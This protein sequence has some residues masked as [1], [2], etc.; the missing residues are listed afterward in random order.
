MSS[1][2]CAAANDKMYWRMYAGHELP[3]P[4]CRMIQRRSAQHPA[5]VRW[6]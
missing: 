2:G 3:S 6:R 4:P 5:V 1:A